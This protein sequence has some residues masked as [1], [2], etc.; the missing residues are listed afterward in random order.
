MLRVG[1]STNYIN[2][3]NIWLQEVIGD[4]S[5]KIKSLNLLISKCDI[6]TTIVAI[7]LTFSICQILWK[8]ASK[9][10]LNDPCPPGMD[11]PV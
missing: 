8:G 11:A 1:A 4:I 3:S 6:V 5:F 9:M 2:F 7:H 10:V